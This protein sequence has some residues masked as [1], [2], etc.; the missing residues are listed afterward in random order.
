MTVNSDKEKPNILIK[1]SGDLVFDSKTISFI[2]QKAKK[3]YVVILVGGGTDI[4]KALEEYHR[5]KG[6]RYKPNFVPAL[7]RKLKTFRERQ[8]AR[9]ILEQNQKALQDK[10]VGTT[11]VAV[12]IPVL[13]LGGVLSHVNADNLAEITSLN[14][15][16]VY[17]LTPKGRGDTK[18][19]GHY[20]NVEVKEF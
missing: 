13:H 20:S 9:D 2:K 6:K 10:L 16:K 18:N 3:N 5:K 19:F 15:K 8:I 14:F 12:E 7:G 17:V 4:T 1:V 11:G